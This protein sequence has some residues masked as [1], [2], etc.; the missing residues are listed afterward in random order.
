MIQKLPNIFSRIINLPAYLLVK[1]QSKFLFELGKNTF[2]GLSTKIL[3]HKYIRIADNVRVGDNSIIT[4]WDSY[5]LIKFNPQLIIKQNTTIGEYAHIT[6]I[7][8]VLLQKNI[9]I[10]K[11]VTITDNSH[12]D[13]R[14]TSKIELLQNPKDRNLYSKGPVIIC[15]N[16]WIGDKVSILPNVTIGKSSIVGANSVVTKNI[17]PFCIYAGNPAKLIKK[18]N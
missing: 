2:L 16:V 1:F 3:G 15:E 12:G 17:P 5:N 14:K 8:K 13:P 9:M 11:F 6:C 18:L 4:A 7:N 10:G